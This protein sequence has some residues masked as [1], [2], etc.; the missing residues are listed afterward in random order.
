MAWQTPNVSWKTAD[1]Y[2]H[3]DWLRVSENLTL[4]NLWLAEHNMV[5]AGLQSTSIPRGIND[6]PSKQ[7]VNRLEANLTAVYKA[8]G[9]SLVE[10]VPSVDWR[11]RL[12]ALYVRNPNNE[13]WIRWEM[14]SK[15]INECIEYLDYYLYQLVGG[16]FYAGSN[17]NIQRF[18]R[19]R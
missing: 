19:G 13:D 16:T 12:D 7:L 10:W 4:V 18:S 1:Y 15:R 3:Q 8:L 2:S 9:F 5:S 6:L 11:S 14:L 17:S